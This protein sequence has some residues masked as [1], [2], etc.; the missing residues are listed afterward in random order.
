MPHID[1]EGLVFD[2]EY[3]R[4]TLQADVDAIAPESVVDIHLTNGHT[5]PVRSVVGVHSEYA[6]FQ[7]YR[8]R[9]LQT[10]RP[11][12]WN[13]DASPGQPEE[14]THRAVVSY[15]GIVAVTIAPARPGSGRNVGFGPSS[16]PGA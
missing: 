1:A 4:T 11:L 9:N 5:L 8:G 15:A 12:C 10:Q 2:S 6:T 13:G 16:A 14:E 3:F 7:A